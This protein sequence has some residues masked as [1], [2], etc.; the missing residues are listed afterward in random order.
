MQPDLLVHHFIYLFVSKPLT[1]LFFHYKTPN[2]AAKCC[3]SVQ[4]GAI[5]G[6]PI[7]SSAM[8]FHRA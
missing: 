1:Q 3:M 4:I 6:T 5:T 2:L 7:P 8:N